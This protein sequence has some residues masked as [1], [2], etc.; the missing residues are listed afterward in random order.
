LVGFAG[1]VLSAGQAGVD[2]YMYFGIC[3]YYPTCSFNPFFAYL[4]LVLLVFIFTPLIFITF[5]SPLWNIHRFMKASKRVAEDEFANR[6]A[7]LEEQIRSHVD[8]DG[9]IDKAKNARD[10]LEII[11]A[12]N[13]DKS[14]YPVWPF[15]AS[16]MIT[17]FSPQLLSI[18]GF[19]LSVYEAFK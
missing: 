14:G 3:R 12:I 1:L 10:K 13:P 15:R 8:A 7:S 16:L 4:S 2:L 11:Q 19:G 17:L 6:V 5:F 18:V 9:V